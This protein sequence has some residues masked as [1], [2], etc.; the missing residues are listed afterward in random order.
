MERP[1]AAD[2]FRHHALQRRASFEMRKGRCS[3]LNRCIILSLNR[4]R[5]KELC[6]H[7]FARIFA[8]STAK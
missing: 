1:K 7:R 8:T 5:F 6:S 4:F 3:T 2:T